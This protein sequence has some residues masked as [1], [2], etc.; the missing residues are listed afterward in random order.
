ML[1]WRRPAGPKAECMASRNRGHLQGSTGPPILICP[2]GA[3]VPDTKEAVLGIWIFLCLG[4]TTEGESQRGVRERVYVGEE[5][6]VGKKGLRRGE[7][8]N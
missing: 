6:L 3:R 8:D 2:L 1:E 7:R 5:R 4:K